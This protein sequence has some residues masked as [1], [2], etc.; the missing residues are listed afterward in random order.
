MDP[1]KIAV[2]QGWPPPTT[3]RSLRGFLG[4]TGYYRRFNNNHGILDAP[5]T[6]LLKES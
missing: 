4:L 6:K 1:T 3:V 5:L 2:V